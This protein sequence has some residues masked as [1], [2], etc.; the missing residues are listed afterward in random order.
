MV[1]VDCDNCGETTEK[2]PAK[3][4]RN[5]HVFCSREC[6]HDHG[7]PDMQGENNPNPSKG[8]VAVDCE[9]C[10]E[11]FEVYPY[12]EDSARFCSRECKDRNLA[13]KTG[14]DTPAWKGSKCEYECQNCG[15]QFSDYSCREE[16]QYCSDECYREA[17]KEMFSGDGNPVW[18]GGRVDNYGPNW[19]DQ[20]E[21]AL[22]R[23]G[24]TCQECGTHTDE[25]EGALHVHHKKRIGW[26][27]E[28]YDAPEWYERANRVGN[29]LTLCASCHLKIEWSEGGEI[30]G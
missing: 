27:K 30:S 2:R 19:K 28:E 23:D 14:E 13:G 25:K 3:V 4:K 18:R 26:F 8:K 1:E 24:H 21:K 15:Q 22:D 16:R 20:R 17:S 10:G 6:Y 12:R 11:S 5:D 29:L 9:V 7:R